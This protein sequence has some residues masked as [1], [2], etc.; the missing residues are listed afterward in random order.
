MGSDASKPQ[1]QAANEDVTSEPINGSSSSIAASYV[2]SGSVEDGS[3]GEQGNSTTPGHVVILDGSDGNSSHA[4]HN[5]VRSRIVSKHRHRLNRLDEDAAHSFPYPVPEQSIAQSDHGSSKRHKKDVASLDKWDRL[6]YSITNCTR[7]PKTPGDWIGFFLPAYRWL[8]Q[9]NVRTTLQK[10]IIAGLTVGVMIVPQSM[11]YAKLAG[12]PVQYG[13]Y[14]SLVPIYLYSLFGSSRQ[15]AVGPV[16]LVSLM[17]STGLSNIMAKRAQSDPTLMDA[18][19]QNYIDQYVILAIQTSFLVGVLNIGLGLARLGFIT[20]FLSHAVISG[21]ISGAA[22]IIGASQLKLIFGVNVERSDLIY[23]ILRDLFKSLGQTNWKV[24]VMGSLSLI[25]LISFKQIGKFVPRLKWMQALGPL[26]VTVIGIIL[27]ATL[28]LDERGIDVVGEIPQ[29]LPDFTAGLWTPMDNIGDLFVTVVSIVLIGFMESIAIAR[30]FAAIHRYEI[31]PSLELVGL[32]FAN[33]FGGM[34]QAYPVTGSFSR[35]AVNNDSGAQSGIAGVITATLVMIVL[36]VLTSV[37]ELLPTA[38]LGAIVIAGVIGLVDYPEAIN[39]WKVHKKDFLC[40]L[41]A[42]LG[43]MFLGVEL[44]LAVAVGLSLLIVLYESAYPKTAV[45]GRLKGTTVYRNIKQYPDAEVFDGIVLIRVDAPLY[46][47]NAQ[48]VREKVRKYR[49]AAEESSDMDDVRF[50]IMDMTP[51]SHI[52][53]SALH[54]L[55]DMY[56]NYRSRNQQLCF[57]NPNL[58]LMQRFDA[59]GFTDKVGRHLFFACTHDAVKWCLADMDMETLS[60]HG[61]AEGEHSGDG[62]SEG[63]ASAIADDLESPAVPAG[64]S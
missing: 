8:K 35:S 19:S 63:V 10:D 37:F 6:Q 55:N 20:I 32:G 22:I 42:F 44:G 58:T 38:I 28:N 45:L 24:F 57:S 52:D 53:T 21:F 34:F 36:L 14:S 56:D 26:T 11:S 48:H 47:A 31:D 54:V 23:E 49:L 41:C 61:D 5:G 29:G 25:T 30:K 15:L 18:T 16:A 39:L 9:Y 1:A 43:S 4:N 50:L 46:F 64:S 12:L 33:L 17:V 13:L 40:W 62:E 51:V 3:G 27:V 60:A 59:S 7:L 2:A